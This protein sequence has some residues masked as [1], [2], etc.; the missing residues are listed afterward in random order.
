MKK[1]L[2]SLSRRKIYAQKAADHSTAPENKENRDLTSFE[3]LLCPFCLRDSA[4][5]PCTFGT[6]SDGILQSLLDLRSGPV[7]TVPEASTDTF[8]MYMD[9]SI[10]VYVRNVN[11]F[12]FTDRPTQAAAGLH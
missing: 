3:N 4:L 12:I 7:N 1:A 10:I 11:C 5:Q 2:D 6:Q 9:Y 8:V